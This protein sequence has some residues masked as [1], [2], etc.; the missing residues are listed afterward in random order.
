MGGWLD[1]GVDGVVVGGF[2]SGWLGGWMGVPFQPCLFRS[3]QYSC[4]ELF[5]DLL[6]IF[7]Q[8]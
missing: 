7:P 1:G 8:H 4:F 3:C 5:S 6:N 2:M